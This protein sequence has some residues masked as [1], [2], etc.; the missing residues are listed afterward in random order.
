MYLPVRVFCKT[1]HHIPIIFNI[2]NAVYSRYVFEFNCGIE[3]EGR[4][5]WRQTSRASVPYPVQSTTPA[6]TNGK[7]SATTPPLVPSRFVNFSSP[8]Q[9]TAQHDTSQSGK[10]SDA[11]RPTRLMS[12]QRAPLS[13]RHELYSGSPPSSPPP[14]VPKASSDSHICGQEQ[15]DVGVKTDDGATPS[16][17]ITA[18][19]P[20]SETPVET[21]DG[22]VSPLLQTLTQELDQELTNLHEDLCGNNFKANQI[23]GSDSSKKQSPTDIEQGNIA[24]EKQEGVNQPKPTTTA[25]DGLLHAHLRGGGSLR[26][27]ST[28]SIDSSIRSWNAA[29]PSN[30][31][32]VEE[33][34]PTD[35]PSLIVA[36]SQDAAVGATSTVAYPPNPPTSVHGSESYS[37]IGAGGEVSPSESKSPVG[38]A[39]KIQERPSSELR[40]KQNMGGYTEDLAEKEGSTLGVSDFIPDSPRTSPFKSLWDPIPG[41][42]ERRNAESTSP[43]ALP[44]TESAK[45]ETSTISQAPRQPPPPQIPMNSATSK[46]EGS[47]THGSASPP[48]TESPRQEGTARGHRRQFSIIMNAPP[49]PPTAIPPEQPIRSPPPPYRSPRPDELHL[50]YASIA[51]GGPVTPTSPTHPDRQEINYTDFLSESGGR[52]TLDMTKRTRRM[53]PF[54]PYDAPP[55][56]THQRRSAVSERSRWSGGNF[57]E[58]EPGDSISTVGAE[59]ARRN[60]ASTTPT[61][62]KST[63]VAVLATLNEE[64]VPR[65]GEVEDAQGAQERGPHSEINRIYQEHSEEIRAIT[66][67]AYKPDFQKQVEINGALERLQENLQRA[68]EQQRQ[69]I[70]EEEN[71]R[72]IRGAP[73]PGQFPQPLQTQTQQ[74]PSQ[75][76]EQREPQNT[77]IPQPHGTPQDDHHRYPRLHSATKKLGR[78]LRWTLAV[79]GDIYV[80]SHSSSL[81]APLHPPRPAAPAPAPTGGITVPD[82]RPTPQTYSHDPRPHTASPLHASGNVGDSGEN[83]PLR[84]VHQHRQYR[85]TMS[86]VPDQTTRKAHKRRSL[87]SLFHPHSPALGRANRA[88][89]AEQGPL[90]PPFAT[91]ETTYVNSPV[92]HGG[93]KKAGLAEENARKGGAGGE[94]GGSGYAASSVTQWPMG[95]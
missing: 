44:L 80:K 68:W 36:P 28:S 89:Q 34:K 77:D 50:D 47:T 7:Q 27:A 72:H 70:Q 16:L 85:A 48:S 39:R 78:M 9:I 10:Q 90:S 74:V 6:S 19:P 52:D 79:P 73:S 22:L 30:E 32:E 35:E 12:R 95:S 1:P 49:Q 5:E 23:T 54:S 83:H 43:S 57:D 92:G 8:K 62:A 65:G 58:I 3:V 63:P 42:N 13:P 11:S 2:A 56:R 26:P 94:G 46:P 82:S 17:T 88:G 25:N 61:A 38:L 29:N 18:A 40:L 4:I 75:Q 93:G 31:Y 66:H 37:S 33:E 14:V 84:P 51:T 64:P 71:A 91:S 53:S 41:S 45:D 24:T 81:P 86:T 55:R 87:S 59:P 76:H 60:N 21:R 67:D 20:S 15:I 69:Q